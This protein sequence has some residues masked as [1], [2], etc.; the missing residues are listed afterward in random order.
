MFT[1]FLFPS[2][3][4]QSENRASRIL[5]PYSFMKTETAGRRLY[6]CWYQIAR[7]IP[8]DRNARMTLGLIV[9]VGST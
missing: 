5:L 4:L 1:S 2:F 9:S 6:Q 8:G 7:E 3:I